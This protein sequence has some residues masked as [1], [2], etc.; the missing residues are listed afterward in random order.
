L[1]TVFWRDMLMVGTAINIIAG[2]SA[3][4]L[5]VYKMPTAICLLV[6]FSPLPWNLFLFLSVWRSAENAKPPDALVAKIG[7]PLWFAV[8]LAL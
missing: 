4:L 1:E 3:I 2:A 6:F 5:L 8:M 7:A